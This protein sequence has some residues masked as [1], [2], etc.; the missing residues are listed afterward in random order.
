MRLR[1]GGQIVVDEYLGGPHHRLI[2]EDQRATRSVF[3]LN[4]NF[5][6]H[7][8]RECARGYSRFGCTNDLRARRMGSGFTPHFE[9]YFIF[10]AVLYLSLTC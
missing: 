10:M 2:A 8:M 3:N 4:A 9:K 1:S 6:I 5:M 7:K